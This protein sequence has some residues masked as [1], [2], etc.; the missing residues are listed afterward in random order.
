MKVIN[1]FAAPGVGKS[2]T[3][4][5]LSGLLSIA[6]YKVEYIPEFAKFATFSN[7]VAALTDQIY[8]FAKQENRL[9]VLK[10]AGLD[11]V[12]MDGPLP[13]ALL[14]CPPTYYKGYAPLVAEV[15]HSYD[16]VNF[17]LRRN[18]DLRYKQL[19][20]TQSEEESERIERQLRSLLNTHGIECAERMTSK[21]LPSALFEEI[22]GNPSPL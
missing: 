10:D 20:R 4:Q 1:L 21:A 18:P 5:I 22:T 13:V 3:G 11:Y 17:F 12:I 8:M 6:D 7:N 14:Y 15:F 16:N 2:T 19:G 9:H